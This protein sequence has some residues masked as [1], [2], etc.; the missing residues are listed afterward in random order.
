MLKKK[1]LNPG[2]QEV[3]TNDVG[4]VEIGQ[5]LPE[6][7]EVA[8]EQQEAREILG[9]E[10]TEQEVL[11]QQLESM[12]AP[13]AKEEVSAPTQAKPELLDEKVS[14]LL[15]VAKQKGVA[16]AV[17]MAEKMD[18]YVLDKFHDAL[19]EQGFYKKFKQ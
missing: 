3:S 14:K 11:H 10:K 16:H 12:P 18:P 1:K 4:N 5:N 17:S 8:P 2:A 19:A 6:A 13:V 9:Q 15:E 7:L